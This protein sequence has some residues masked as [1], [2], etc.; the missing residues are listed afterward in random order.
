MESYLN[1]K[2]K[3]KCACGSDEYFKLF[4]RKDAN[5]NFEII[6]CKNC[7][8]VRTLP[9]PDYSEKRYEN[10]GIE[11]YIKNKRLTVSFMKMILKEVV[12]F[13]KKGR[14]LEVGCNLGYFLEIAKNKGFDIGGVELDGKAVNYANNILGRGVV[15][16]ST[17]EQANFPNNYFDIIVVSHVLEHLINIP[18]FLKEVKRILNKQGIVVIASP[19]L[20]GLCAKIKKE[21]WPG[22]RPDEHVWQ[23][24]KN[25]ITKFLKEEGFVVIHGKTSGLYHNLA[26][27]M[28]DA[29]DNMRD[30]GSLKQ[31]V[32][33]VLNWLFGK[34]GMGDNVFIVAA[35]DIKI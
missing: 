17:L 14:L 29:R 8:L 25:T 23:L 1:K 5:H 22:L 28:K 10:Y 3:I 9:V 32:Y 26:S 13:K 24:S 6:K 30:K 35:N 2:E 27:V 19:N 21:K 15:L 33:S 16:Q 18:N 11:R 34:L 7:G 20:D 4:E 31:I 12:R